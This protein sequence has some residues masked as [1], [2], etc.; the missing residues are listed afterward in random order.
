MARA[1]QTDD[2]NIQLLEEQ[3]ETGLREL[4]EEYRTNYVPGGAVVDELEERFAF[5]AGEPLPH[6]SHAFGEAFAAQDKNNP[7]RNLYALVLNPGLPYRAHT[8]SEATSTRDPHLV[9]PLAQGTVR[10]S[11]LG[12]SRY[13]IFFEQPQGRSLAQ[14]IDKQ[15]RI[16]E[17]KIV[18]HLLTPLVKA[19]QA[20]R[21]QKIYHGNLRPETFFFGPTSM[22]GEC[23][24]AP[25]GTL[26]HFIYHSAERLLAD[27][28]GYGEADEKSDVYAMGVLALEAMYGLDRLKAMPRQDFTAQ[29]LSKGSYQVLTNN[30]EIPVSLQDF[31]RGVL[32]DNIA[33]R[34][35]LA[36]V[37]QFVD[38]KRFNMIAPT[39][40]KDAARPFIF[41]D[42]TIFSRRYLAYVL[43]QHWRQVVKDIR[44][45]N[46][47]RW[48][49]TGLNRPDVAESVYRALRIGSDHTASERQINDMMVRIAIALDPTG[50]LR[51]QT[52]SVRPDGIPLML[53][54][55][56][57][58]GEAEL[59][60]L[61]K[62][63]ES[64]VSAFWVEQSPHNKHTEM[65]QIILRL[66]RARPYLRLSGLGFGIERVLYELNPTLPCQSPQLKG[67][68]ITTVQQALQTL[69]ALSKTRSAEHTLV[70]RHLAAF[71]AAKIDIRK[72]FRHVELSSIE[73][74]L[75]N[76]ELIMLR[77]LSL[78]QQRSGG[79]RLVG[80]CAWGGMYIERMM[81]EIHNRILRKQQKLK[82]RKRASSG[83]LQEVLNLITSRDVGDRDHAGFAHAIA[84]H[85]L[86]NRKI[87][88]LT[89]TQIVEYKSKQMGGQMAV[90]ISYFGLGIVALYVFGGMMGL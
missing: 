56:M 30:R 87:H 63:I 60:S 80:L 52:I 6:Y 53:S 1:A 90:T 31:F 74:L 20:L 50:P 66:Q 75:D 84:L 64:D 32:T 59:T 72:P 21:A 28:L 58:S 46:I 15:T 2:S 48:C 22:L 25:P 65:S 44:L 37:I 62:L 24:S 45:L 8:V 43:H 82:L 23:F 78:A 36:Q 71:L 38:G 83:V 51:A 14:L 12:E 3:V 10:C 81:S 79:I 76:Q 41:E 4:L 17:S 40:P 57:G 55:L 26:N 86:N 47:E 88:Y 34:W 85:Q 69:D 54:A 73:A 11:H 18:S 9:L 61:L 13:V 68:H 33:E 35:T 77:I 39:P 42:E 49:E 27:P 5:D 19:L 67:Y 7:A 89:N 29:M 70:D 16:H